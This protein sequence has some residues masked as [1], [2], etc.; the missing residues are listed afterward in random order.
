[1]NCKAVAGVGRSINAVRVLVVAH[2]TGISRHSHHSCPNNS[3]TECMIHFFNCTCHKSSSCRCGVCVCV[4]CGERTNEGNKEVVMDGD[5]SMNVLCCL[6]RKANLTINTD[7]YFYVRFFWEGEEKVKILFG[8]L[9]FFV[10]YLGSFDKTGWILRHSYL[11]LYIELTYTYYV[12][13]FV[14]SL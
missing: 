10:F 6:M 14:S 13:A 3:L 8:K 2:L 11:L 9:N 4:Q 1:M 12:H 5:G 7:I